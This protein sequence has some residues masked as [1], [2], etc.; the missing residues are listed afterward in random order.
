M[1]NNDFCHLH[2]HNEFS[3]LDGYGNAKEYVKQAKKMGFN[4]LALT[5]HSNIDGLIKFQQECDKNKIIPIMGCEAYIVPDAAKK[6]KREQRGHITLLIKDQTGYQNL[7]KMLTFANLHGFYSRPRI[8]YDLL[9]DH[10][11]GLVIMSACASSF[12]HLAGSIPFLQDLLYKIPDDVYLEVMP[13]N[14]EAQKKTNIL[15]SDLSKKMNLPMVATNDCHYIL[16]DEW[17]VQ[18]VLLAIQTQAVMSNPD[19]YQFS[20]RGL[21]LR[22]VEEM[23]TTFDKQNILSYEEVGDA[24]ITTKKIAE[25]CQDFRILKQDIYLPPVPGLCSNPSK[26]II[27]TSVHSLNEIAKT[28]DWTNEKLTIYMDR[29]YEEWKVINE[30]KFAG[31]FCIVYELAEWC[32]ANDIM[33]GPGRGSVG[34]SLLAYLLHITSVDP[35]KFDLLFSRFIADDRIDYPDID[36]DFQDS[37]RALVRQHLEQLYGKNNISSISTFLTMKGRAAVR[38]VARV[39][40]IPLDQVDAFAKVVDNAA[41]AEDEGVIEKAIISTP[42]GKAFDRKYPDEV[43]L[44]IKLEGQIRGTGQHAAAVVISADDLTQGTRGNLALRSG[45]VV[46][47]WDMTDSEFVG[48]MK[49]DVLGLNTLSILNE[50]RCLVKST[51]GIDLDFEKISLSDEDVFREL[52]EGHTVGVFQ[53]STWPMTKLVKEVKC[54]NIDDVADI[55]ALVRPGPTDSGMTANYI[56]RKH[57]AKWQKKHPI[58]EKILEKTYGIVVYQ[59]QVMEII[60]KVAGL[61]YVMADKIRKIIGK[62][63]DAKLFKP[64]E[65]AFIDGCLKQKTLSEDEANEFW[66]MLQACANYMFNK[67]HAIEYAILGYWTA[68]CKRYYSTEFICASLTYGSEGK[69]DEII[70][71]AYRLGLSIVLPIIGQSDAEKWVAKENALYVP[72]IEVKGIGGKTAIEAANFKR[73]IKSS[74]GFFHASKKDEKKSKLEIMLED[75]GAFGDDPKG[76]LSHYFSFAIQ[77]DKRV[78][79]PKL[80]KLLSFR[81]SEREIDSFLSLDIS[82]LVGADSLIRRVSFA[83]Y[84]QSLLDCYACSLG[85]EC[86]APVPPSPGIYNLAIFGEA[87]GKD[88]DDQGQGFVGKSGDMLWN[89]FSLYGLLRDDFHISNINKCY[90]RLTR[91]PAK[92]QIAKCS[93]W[94]DFEINQI[95]PILI[96]AFGNTSMKAFHGKDTGITDM[97]G[98]T[99]WNENVGAWIC[100]CIHPSAVLHNPNNKQIFKDGIKNFSDKIRILGDIS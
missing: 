92:E 51:R 80:I 84:E 70:E 16:N 17:K 71:E 53:L 55:I 35:I 59:E 87:P 18:E 21:Y 98:K 99:T 48:L 75:I 89:E 43:D 56:K 64:F 41:Q 68:Y 28:E 95:K 97:S 69:R 79:Y 39:F 77:R 50:T 47:N 11:E 72:F 93:V 94:R 12:L 46:S 30:K 65:D 61:P 31:Y 14:Y 27:D 38:D 42:E 13:H 5:N 54:T 83:K 8:D 49:L 9:Y 96:L 26:F 91:T 1:K 32:R 100:W 37:K 78:M 2:V 63:R 76:D 60:N 7:C 10:C 66:K 82:P 24:I 29:L 62:K 20:V 88:E 22:S 90:P 67:S 34:G 25:K 4:Y 23:Q 40:E 74:K 19:R 33:I 44:M 45:M 52:S 15:C 3:L 86:K 58:Y 73:R 36:L 85:K 81:I 57:G 6:N